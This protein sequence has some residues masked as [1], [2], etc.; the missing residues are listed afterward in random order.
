MA[1]YRMG[2]WGGPMSNVPVWKE[3]LDEIEYPPFVQALPLSK[4]TTR[5][6]N[7]FLRHQFYGAK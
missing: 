6:N 1:G 3:F 4:P 5:W 7:H 2:G